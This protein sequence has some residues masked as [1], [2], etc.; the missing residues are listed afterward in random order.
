MYRERCLTDLPARAFRLSVRLSAWRTHLGLKR[1][2]ADASFFIR[3]QT[4]RI[5]NTVC[6][7]AFRAF[8]AKRCVV[9]APSDRRASV[10]PRSVD[11]ILSSAWFLSVVLGATEG[12]AGTT[13][14]YI[15]AEVGGHAIGAAKA[16][17]VEG[18]RLW[19]IGE[20]VSASV[21]RA[22]TSRDES[23]AATDQFISAYQAGF[24]EARSGRIDCADA[25]TALRALEDKLA[26][27]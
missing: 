20:R 26:K 3:A 14:A 10:P 12:W 21:H 16:C 4:G 25:R 22:A 19:Q 9:V 23:S 18:K 17:G 5:E 15:I 11:R 6:P 24:D 13:E 8:R 7:F 27:D 2:L 1:V